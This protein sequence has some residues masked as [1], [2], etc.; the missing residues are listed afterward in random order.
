MRDIS[1]AFICKYGAL[2]LLICL[3]PSN[4]IIKNHVLI[5]RAAADETKTAKHF[6]FR[7][8][9]YIQLKLF[10]N[11]ILRQFLLFVVPAWK[12]LEANK[13]SCL[14]TATVSNLKLHLICVKDVAVVKFSS[15]HLVSEISA[16]IRDLFGWAPR[17]LNDLTETYHSQLTIISS[18]TR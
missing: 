10:L 15:P 14:K 6:S 11:R 5:L 13:K 18:C 8:G 17:I 7:L 3:L 1:K 4:G 2:N 12:H 16:V 9:I